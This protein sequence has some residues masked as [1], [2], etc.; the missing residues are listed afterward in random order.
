MI[1]FRALK[2]NQALKKIK[3]KKIYERK[4]HIFHS[5]RLPSVCIDKQQQITP[6]SFNKKGLLATCIRGYLAHLAVV[7]F[8][9]FVAAVRHGKDFVEMGTLRVGDK[10]LAHAAAAHIVHNALDSRSIEFVE[11]VV[12][13]EEGHTL[14]ALAAKEIVLRQ[15]HGNEIGLLLALRA[16]LLHGVT[17]E[18]EREFILVSTVQRIT[19]DA[20]FGTAAAQLLAERT[21]LQVALIRQRHLLMLAPRESL[22]GG[23]EEGDE[24]L[25]ELRAG[26]EECLAI[27]G[28]HLF[29]HIEHRRIGFV[30]G[31]QQNVALLE[32]TLVTYQGV[33]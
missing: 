12:E 28:H 1:F 31:T 20:L 3:R 10:N 13:Q 26:C 19:H 6:I 5:Q 8:E 30:I 29:E 18:Q 14:L 2:I 24:S 15:F 27:V 32:S 16:F 9:E 22:V 4:W 7:H 17:V 23:T 33:K 21:A 11:D 25:D